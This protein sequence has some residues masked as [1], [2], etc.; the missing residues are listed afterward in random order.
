[1]VEKG[2]RGGICHAIHRYAKADNKYV[3]D[4]D[5]NEESSN[6][7]YWYVNNL[8]EWEMSQKL[9]L[10]GF[11]WVEETSRFNEGFI[12]SYNDNSDEGFFLEVD[13]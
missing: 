7:T 6:L 3:K 9:P 4:Y 10:D 13:V 8:C 12:K 5:K 11:K 1:M 2:I